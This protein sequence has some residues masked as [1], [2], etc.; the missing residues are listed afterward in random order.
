[1]VSKAE[2]RI[3]EP[4]ERWP[5][6]LAIQC[7]KDS[8]CVAQA[9]LDIPSVVNWIEQGANHELCDRRAC[10]LVAVTVAALR[11]ARQ[12][13]ITPAA[14]RNHY[15]ELADRLE[16]KPTGKRLVKLRRDL[17][18]DKAAALHQQHDSSDLQGLA[19]IARVIAGASDNPNW[20]APRPNHDHAARNDFI[21]ALTAWQREFTGSPSHVLTT[22]IT[23]VLFKEQSDEV[24]RDTVE[25]LT[26]VKKPAADK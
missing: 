24:H 9:I 11:N 22:D 2:A 1:V 25:R 3:G 10:S 16:R 21:Q 17:Q 7:S 12:P 14:H 18:H 8:E 5:L 13:F 19:A 6:T 4:P 26:R 23:S 20:T 15:I